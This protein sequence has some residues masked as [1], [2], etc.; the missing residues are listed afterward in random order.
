[1]CL[2]QRDGAEKL[3]SSFSEVP[4]PSTSEEAALAAK[5]ISK[6]FSWKILRSW[7]KRLT[8]QE[9]K[10]LPKALSV[11]ALHEIDITRFR[12]S[13]LLFL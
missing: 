1:M 4:P 2:L 10:V 5:A 12:L 7:Q 6:W 13:G 11:V 9:V 3:T 8:N